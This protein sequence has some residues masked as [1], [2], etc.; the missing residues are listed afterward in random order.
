MLSKDTSHSPLIDVSVMDNM[1]KLCNNTQV[2]LNFLQVH[3]IFLRMLHDTLQYLPTYLE[4]DEWTVTSYF[5]V[6]Q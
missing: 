3:D 4:A 5:G 2:E 6:S 1:M